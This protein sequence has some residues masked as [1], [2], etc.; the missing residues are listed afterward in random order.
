[1]SSQAVQEYNTI[2]ERHPSLLEESRDY[3]VQRVE[4]VRFVFGGRILSPYL[5]PHFVTRAEWRQITAACETVWGA[6]EKVGRNAPIDGLMLEQ[7]GITEAERELVAVDPGYD[8]VSV[9]SRLDSF[10]TPERY[11]FV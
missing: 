3:L 4:E 5:R 10:L 2:I 1:M 6:I 9:S 7:I 8:H 11:S